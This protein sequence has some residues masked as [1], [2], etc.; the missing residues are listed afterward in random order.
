MP[1]IKRD[2]DV[3][4]DDERRFAIG[5][6]IGYFEKE[7]GEKIGVVA[8]GQLLDLLLRITYAPVYNKVLDNVKSLLEKA[9]EDA[10]ISLRK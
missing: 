3:L 9:L 8:A 10:D 5:E 4:S 6:I 1:E 7:R 2:W